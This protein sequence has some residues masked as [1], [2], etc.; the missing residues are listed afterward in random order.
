[1]EIRHYIDDIDE[2]LFFS[3]KKIKDEFTRIAANLWIQ[4]G[5]DLTKNKTGKKY[6]V[7]D[8]IWS[9]KA[10]K[11]FYELNF[12]IIDKMRKKQQ[13]GWFIL[14]VEPKDETANEARNIFEEIE[15]EQRKYLKNKKKINKY[16]ITE[17]SL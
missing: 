8:F 3:K 9:T 12:D 2:K 13:Y 14:Q 10:K 1:M 17:E 11:R 6:N 5:V 4:F 15:E 16:K 7:T